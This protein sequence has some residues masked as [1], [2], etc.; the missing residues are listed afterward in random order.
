MDYK[1]QIEDTS[2]QIYKVQ[3]L[4][5]NLKKNDLELLQARRLIK[6]QRITNSYVMS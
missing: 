6:E 4:N 5:I 3:N 2:T 1:Y